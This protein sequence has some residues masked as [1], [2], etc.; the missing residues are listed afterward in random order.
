MALKHLL[1]FILLLP[2]AFA[3]DID[4]GIVQE[5]EEN[6]TARVIIEL[7]D[8]PQGSI[9]SFLGIEET[10]EENVAKAQQQAL[11]NIRT[12]KVLFLEQELDIKHQYK[13]IHAL[14]GTINE[15]ALEKLQN[16]EAVM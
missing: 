1:I 16:N 13:S 7:E 15:A 11:K 2:I 9:S 10:N 3:V 4:P 8:V 6:K 5:I 14:A 12:E